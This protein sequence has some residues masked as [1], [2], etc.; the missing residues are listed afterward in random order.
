MLSIINMNYIK[1]IKSLGF[2]S[3]KPVVVCVSSWPKSE[4]HL[5]SID[6]ILSGYNPN[7]ETFSELLNRKECF[8]KIKFLE[9]DINRIL[10]Y[11][12]RLSDVIIYI[13]IIGGDYTCILD[14]NG[15]TSIMDR[16]KLNPNFWKDILASLPKALQ[17]EMIIKEIFKYQ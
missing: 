2:K 16:G 1:K 10:S 3:T 14:G 8:Y 7:K 9:S 4:Y 17:R 12:L 5:K 15:S 11:S 13:I 6:D